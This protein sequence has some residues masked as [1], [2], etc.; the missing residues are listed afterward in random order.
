[1]LKDS[2]RV[3]VL[4]LKENDFNFGKL[5]KFK[6]GDNL[7]LKL[8]NSIIHKNIRVFCNLPHD[9]N[10]TFNRAVYHEYFWA[11]NESFI[12]ND[13]FDRHVRINC[14]IPGSF[15]FYFTIAEEGSTKEYSVGGSSFLIDPILKLHNGQQISFNSLQ[16][17]TVITKLLG[18][19]EEWISRLKV[20]KE[21][22]YNMIHFTPIQELSKQSNSSYCIKDHMKLINSAN[23]N[24]E[25]NLE[26][27]KTLIDSIYRD[28]NIFSICDL[29]YNHMAN[30]SE[31]LQIYPQATYNLKNS[32]HLIPA[33]I[34][35]RIL[36]HISK[37]ISIGA[38]E[39]QGILKEKFIECN[40]ETLRQIIR[41][42]EIPKYK[43]EEFFTIDL[44]KALN[45]IHNIGLIELKNIENN[46]REF[47]HDILSKSSNSIE[48]EWKK[49]KIV[50]DPEFKRLASGIDENVVKS[51]FK[52]EF[53]RMNLSLDFE[54]NKKLMVSVFERFKTDLSRQNE[55]I[56]NKIF[57]YLDEAVNNVVSNAYYHFI[58]N[59]GPKW[60]KVTVETPIVGTYF[61]CPFENGDPSSDE[62]LAFNDEKSVQIQA[63]NGW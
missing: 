12:I 22:G 39:N 31:F 51:I 55:N 36:Y 28:W 25:H 11:F 40:I 48:D 18:P 7:H 34:L 17:N 54:N 57:E 44:R 19:F 5:Y 50:Q 45:K 6:Q 49:L 10:E 9:K 42:Q 2:N 21:T 47:K 59:D 33:F 52:N 35:D 14:N 37:D 13:D 27:L 1:M 8:S 4:F 24:F 56:K 63:H 61:Y 38:Y 23:K 20:V 16:I 30:D 58:S 3:L 41:D 43:L 62:G 53:L 26:D 32:R 60:K 15:E 46:I 29:V